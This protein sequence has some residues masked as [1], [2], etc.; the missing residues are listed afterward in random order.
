LR[1]QA[2][3]LLGLVRLF[4]RNRS[5]RRP[6]RS[7]GTDFCRMIDRFMV[8]WEKGACGLSNSLPHWIKNERSLGPFV[9][10][11]MTHL[12]WLLIFAELYFFF[13]LGFT[14]P[15]FLITCFR[16]VF[17]L[18]F[19]DAGLDQPWSWSDVVHLPIVKF[20]LI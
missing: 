10:L 4:S 11:I 6:L 13:L 17:A 18:T 8:G 3:M 19:G 14:E 1:A 7:P 16:C 20:L 5:L 9:G 12:T 15:S 2:S